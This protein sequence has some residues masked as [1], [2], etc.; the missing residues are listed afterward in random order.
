MVAYTV[1]PYPSAG[2]GYELELY[3]AVDKCEG[4]ARGFYHYDAGATR[5]GRR[6]MRQ[7]QEFEALLTGAANADGRGRRAA[8]SDHD[9]AP[10]LAGFHGNTARS[11]TL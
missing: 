11:P 9:R 4:L 10:D 8:D 2:A 7:R 6:S 3:L 5:V 1:R